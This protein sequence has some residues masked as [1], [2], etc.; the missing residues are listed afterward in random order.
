MKDQMKAPKCCGMG[1]PKWMDNIV[2][3]KLTDKK[4]QKYQDQGWYS[5]EQKQA[6]M[7][8][9]VKSSKR[10]RQGN[11]ILS[12]DGVLVYCPK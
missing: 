5:Q 4:I 2:L 6:R 10:Y 12:D 8:R 9:A 11:F 1:K 3:G 7:E